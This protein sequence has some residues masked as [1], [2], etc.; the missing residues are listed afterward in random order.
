[1]KVSVS[2]RGITEVFVE[3]PLPGALALPG[4]ANYSLAPQ[5]GMISNETNEYNSLIKTS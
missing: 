4:S 1:M 2:N 3:Q 5:W